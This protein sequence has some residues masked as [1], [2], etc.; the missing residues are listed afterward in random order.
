MKVFSLQLA[1]PA[2]VLAI[3]FSTAS[4]AQDSTGSDFP[5]QS[6]QAKIQYCKTCHGLA[7][8]GYRGF[9]AMPRLAGQQTVYFVNQLKAFADRSRKNQYMY[10]VARTLPRSMM[11]SLATHFSGLNPKP[12]G[13]MRRSLAA[14]GRKIYE[15]GV[16][17]SN[18][19]ACMACHGPAAKGQGEI[20]RLAGQL[21]DYVADT[22]ANWDKTRGKGSGSDVSALM[23]PT[24]HSLTRPQVAA[25]A[26]YVSS[27]Q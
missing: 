23:L 16:P 18:V 10:V 26:A 17:E 2:V 3:A 8:Q 20:P 25:V 11:S 5:R 24:S 12:L 19:P 14:D 1:A 13:G 22:L 27:L 4:R 9:Y 6:L 7:G 21:P 15:E